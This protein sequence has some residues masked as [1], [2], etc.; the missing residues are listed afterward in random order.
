MF[1]TFV[2]VVETQNLSRVA[3]EF[4]IS[5]PAVSKQIQ[6][7]EEMYGVLL[8][9]RAGRRLKPT[10]A[11]EALYRCAREIL[12]ALQK[13]ETVME[14]HSESRK[15]HLLLGA[16][17]IPGHYIMPVLIK[18]F[19]ER[20]PHI[21]IS[22]QVGDTERIVNKVADKE[23][24]IGIVGALLGGRRVD[25]FKWL[26]DE[27]VLVVPKDHPLL[28]SGSVS[29]RDL[30]HEHWIF[31]EKGSG[32]RLTMEETLEAAG[33]RSEDLNVLAEL[34]STEAVLS[35]VEAGMGISLVSY[36]GAREA[37]KA[38]KIKTLKINDVEF[39]RN[40]YVIF[41][42]QKNRR[43]SVESFL[44]FLKEVRE[45]RGSTEN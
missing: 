19:K 13:T 33:L 3:E 25:G 27:L 21:N 43:K 39:K 4:G 2:R 20:A 29:L 45:N 11:G 40:L 17:T 32:T 37:E 15:G 41:P 34:G 36:W 10:D 18:M 6:T 44:E 8:L 42:K 5:Q 16:S 38:G 31:R 35:S 22:M 28:K 12:K 7:L 24:D 30:V 1:R 23:L 9:E 14:D 26:A